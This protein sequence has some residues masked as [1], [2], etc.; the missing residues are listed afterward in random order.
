MIRMQVQFTD[1]QAQALK[2]RAARE[3]VSVSVL[4][5]R[6]VDSLT[7]LERMAADHERRRGQKAPGSRRRGQVLQSSIR[8][9]IRKCVIAR[10]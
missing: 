1:A 9:A 4:V 5:R 3:R 8:D 6:A 10:S 2:Q 7:A